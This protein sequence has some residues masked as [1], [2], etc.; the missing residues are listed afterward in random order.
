MWS[1]VIPTFVLAYLG[2]AAAVFVGALL[3]RRHVLEQ[4][5]RLGLEDLNPQ[6]IGYL[7]LGERLAVYSSLA[8][9]RAAEAVRMNRDKRTLRASR[10]LPA[11]ATTLDRAVY[12]AATE[13]VAQQALRADPRVVEAVG[14]VRSE[15]ERAGLLLG[16]E[17]RRKAR[18]GAWLM[19]ALLAVGVIR[20]SF[21]T[22]DGRLVGYLGGSVLLTLVGFYVLVAR[23]PRRGRAADAMLD[24]LRRT[25]RH[26]GVD[27]RPALRTYGPTAAG[28]AVALFGTGVL[29][30]LDR[31]MGHEAYVEHEDIYTGSTGT[32]GSWDGSGNSYG[33]ADSGRGWRRSRR[34]L[35]R[36]RR[37]VIADQGGPGGAGLGPALPRGA[38]SRRVVR[39]ARTRRQDREPFSCGTDY[40]A[41]PACGSPSCS[42]AR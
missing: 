27:H 37:R 31:N 12:A 16:P 42:S 22:S 40:L 41:R 35:R 21:G 33:E 29:G 25:H 8:G 24:Q 7:H 6:Q 4:P 2:T 26:L 36:W 38:R 5:P 9:L 28:M 13:G 17:V 23:I 20:I 30:Y 39:E 15:V 1:V 11:V 34:W 32:A 18:R 19:L 14:E 3:H 10:S